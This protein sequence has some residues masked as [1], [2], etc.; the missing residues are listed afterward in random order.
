MAIGFINQGQAWLDWLLDGIQNQFNPPR[1]IIELCL[2]TLGICFPN[3][4]VHYKYRTF[5]EYAF[6]TMVFFFG[7]E[8]S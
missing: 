2:P 7:Y 6:S 3:L 8:K 5:Q 1:I 4:T